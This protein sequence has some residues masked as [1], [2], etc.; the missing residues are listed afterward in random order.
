MMMKST[1]FSLSLLFLSCSLFSFTGKDPIGKCFISFFNPVGLKAYEPERLP[2][3]ADKARTLLTEKGEVQVTRTD[4]YRILYG[5]QKDAVFVNLKVESCK[6]EEYEVNKQHLIEN[7]KYLASHTSGMEEQGII[8]KEFNGQ[9]IYGISRNAIEKGTTLG[10]FVL[11]PGN[12]VI[13]YF[14]F[15]NL[16]PETRHFENVTD[17][18]T[19]RDLFLEEYTRHLTNCKE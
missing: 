17:F 16:P 11:F 12:G 8:E 4:G 18:N 10:I 9:T 15:N 13:V 1:F 6:T 3:T 19:Q 2:A 14:Y 7:L 5:N